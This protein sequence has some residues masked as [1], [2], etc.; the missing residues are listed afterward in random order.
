MKIPYNELERIYIA[1]KNDS[2][3]AMEELT[4]EIEITQINGTCKA[5]K[6]GK[7]LYR[8]TAKKVT[9]PVNLR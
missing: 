4:T 5:T 8:R 3:G 2:L 1:A 9:Y 6:N 7:L